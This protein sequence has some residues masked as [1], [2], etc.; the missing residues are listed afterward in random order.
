MLKITMHDSAGEL[1]LQLE[2]RLAGA[3][4]RELRQCWTTAA[5]TTAGRATVLDLGEVDFVDEDGQTLLSEM[6][7]SGVRLLA[8]TPLIQGLVDESCQQFRCGTVEGKSARR[9]HAFVCPD[10]PRS[11]SPP[12]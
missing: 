4:V 10:S 1:R 11:D 6:F 12:L 2:G 5:S 8:I 7:R 3:W 9:S